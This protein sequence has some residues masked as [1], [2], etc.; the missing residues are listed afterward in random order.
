[1]KEVILV[2]MGRQARKETAVPL[3]LMVCPDYLVIPGVRVKKANPV[4]GDSLDHPD[5]F[6]CTVAW[7][8][9][10]SFHL[11]LDLYLLRVDGLRVLKGTKETRVSRGL[12]VTRGKVGPMVNQE[13]LGLKV[14]TERKV[15]G[16]YPVLKETAD[17][18][19]QPDLLDLPDLL[20]KLSV[21][22]LITNQ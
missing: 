7:M 11:E 5:Q 3:V 14:S 8:M 12:L 19:D 9:G 15:N 6:V 16:D 20:H 13:Y 18:P 1:M 21:I 22:P 2:L 4:S 17:Q 10:I